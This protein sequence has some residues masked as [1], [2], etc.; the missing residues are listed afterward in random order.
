MMVEGRNIPTISI[1]KVEKNVSKTYTD[2]ESNIK[3][4]EKIAEITY[5]TF[6]DVLKEIVNNFIENGQIYDPDKNQYFSVK[7]MIKND[8]MEVNENVGNE[9]HGDDSNVN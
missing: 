3:A 2:K 7:E 5:R 6:N 1:K 4:I 9:K 8:A